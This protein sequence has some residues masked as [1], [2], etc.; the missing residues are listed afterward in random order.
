MPPAALDPAVERELVEVVGPAHVVTDPAITASATTD[1][2]GRF[3]GAT[4]ALVRPGSADEVA[5]VLDVC[6]RRSVALVPQGGNTGLV[7]GG[8]ALDG[9][10]VLNLGRLDALD[11]VDRLA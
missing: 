7:G 1:W 3:V 4:P 11:D 5:G 10:V 8:V 2:T 6:R 9:E